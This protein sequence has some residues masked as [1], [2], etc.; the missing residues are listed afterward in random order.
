MS[1]Y[2]S[3]NQDGTFGFKDSEINQ[4]LDNDVQISDDIY[5]QF[6][7]QQAQGKQF[8]I[9]NLQGT[10]FADIFVEFTPTPTPQPPNIEDRLSS[11]EAAIASLMGV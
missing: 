9:G 10:S 1:K 8:K 7:E 4:V 6:F 2:L 5:N 3:V 11:V